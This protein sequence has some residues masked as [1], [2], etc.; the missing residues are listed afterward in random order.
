LTLTYTYHGTRV[1]DRRGLHL[2]SSYFEYFIV[3]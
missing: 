3:G 2:L 1:V